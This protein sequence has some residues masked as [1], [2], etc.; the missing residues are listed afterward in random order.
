MT[1]EIEITLSESELQELVAAAIST[2]AGR[3]ASPDDVRFSVNADG[4]TVAHASIEDV[5]QLVVPHV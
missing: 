3:A 2:A 1:R 4:E 5:V